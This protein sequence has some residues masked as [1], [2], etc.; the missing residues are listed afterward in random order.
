MAPLPA[1]PG[2]VRIVLGTTSGTTNMANVFHASYGGAP[3]SIASVTALANAV[4]TAAGGL[5]TL[6]SPSEDISSCSVT[7]LSSSSGA[8]GEDSGSTPGAAAGADLPASACILVNYSTALRYRGGHP[9][10]YLAIGMDADLA[11]Q[12]TWNN[13]FQVAAEVQFGVLRAAMSSTLGGT[14]Y[15]GQVAVSYINKV[16]NPIAPYHRAVPL[17]L[18][19]PSFRI[20]PKVASQR[21]RLL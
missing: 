4:Y 9:R 18:P 15:T 8:V 17:V 16:S 3:P 7:D 11:D 13:I 19:L 20:N 14:T 12:R 2:V 1:V 6:M 10:Q 5:A 21:R